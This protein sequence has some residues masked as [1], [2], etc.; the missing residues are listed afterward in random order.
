MKRVS[1]GAALILVMSVP[2][3]AQTVG[4]VQASFSATYTLG[5]GADC[6][7]LLV[8]GQFIA[9]TPGYQLTVKKVT[10]QATP[11]IHELELVATPPAGNVTQLLTLMPVS[12]SD[13]DFMSC[14]Y[15]I[16]IAYGKQRVIVGLVPAST[17]VEK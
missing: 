15:G 8:T 5:D 2:S 11:T 17:A 6:K 12:Y 16:S 14:P 10:P 13:P 7:S 1:V 3:F 9:P 4:L